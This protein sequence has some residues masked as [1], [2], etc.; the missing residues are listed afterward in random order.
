MSVEVYMDKKFSYDYENESL[1]I[2]ERDIAE[3][4]K[5]RDNLCII[6]VNYTLK[7]RNIDITVMKRDG[8]FVVEL[9]QCNGWFTANENGVWVKDDGGIIGSKDMNPYQQVLGYR[10]PWFDLLRDNQDN[11]QCLK[12][13]NDERGIKHVKGIVAIYPY[14]NENCIDNV[15]RE[16]KQNWWFHLAG[17]DKVVEIIDR[18][19]YKGINFSDEELRSIANELLNMKKVRL[20]KNQYDTGKR[21]RKI[22][23]SITSLI[24][25]Y[26]QKL[27]QIHNDTEY[28]KK[29]SFE[30]ND[31][32][33]KIETILDKL[34]TAVEKRNSLVKN[35]EDRGDIE[36]F[37]A[38]VWHILST[39]WSSVNKETLNKMVKL[40]S[41][42]GI[43]KEKAVDIMK[44]E[45]DKEKSRRSM[46][47]N[48]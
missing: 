1:E 34:F 30:S 37:H 46:A 6:L 40:S 5:S 48:T 4:F 47:K 7:Q 36:K 32:L 22:S 43:E 12:K 41:H 33:L 38:V 19:T 14:L 45:F 17:I 27:M 26:D 9:K 11:F 24:E 18:E 2:T 25:D 15:P 10:H 13:F 31:R 16:G 8:I 44:K 3:R 39:Y 42:F 29:D 28:L 21:I 23:D 20:Y 35:I